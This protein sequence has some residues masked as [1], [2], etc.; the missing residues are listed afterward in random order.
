MLI[1][2]PGMEHI[3]YVNAFIKEHRPNSQLVFSQLHSDIALEQQKEAFSYAPRGCRKIIISTSIAE[4]SI[5]VPDIRYVVDFCLTKQTHTDELTNLTSLELAWA[6]Q[7]NLDQRRGRAGRVESG[8]CYRLITEEF[9]KRLP[10][11]PYPA[12]LRE[13]LDKV[14]LR[15][16]RILP[17]MAPKNVLA[18]ALTPPSLQDIERTVLKLKECGALS[19]FDRNGVMC[20]YDGNLTWAG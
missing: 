15:T 14:V 5:T 2:V 18:L 13:P 12:I 6:S 17:T 1:F 7:S 16:K 10:Q 9:Y 20:S 11:F 8:I 19:L 4:S 3:N